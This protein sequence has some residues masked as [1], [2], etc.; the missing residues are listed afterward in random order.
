M[1]WPDGAPL[2]RRR[3]LAQTLGG[4]A[5]LLCASRP[6]LSVLASC[7]P[8]AE[9]K[10]KA[11]IQIWLQG[12][13]PHLDTFDPKPGAGRDY[14]GPYAKSIPTSVDGIEI[15]PQLPLLARE[16]DKYALLRGMTHGNNGHETAAYLVQAG[17][18]AGG[19]LVFPGFGSVVASIKAPK[20]DSKNLLPP[21][22]VVPRPQGRFSEAGFLSSKYKPFATG[23]DPNKDPFAVEGLI[24][25]N[26]TEERQ[27][28]RRDLL[29]RL[30]QF[31]GDDPLARNLDGCREQAYSMILGEAG[32]AF[33]LSQ[34]KKEVRDRYGRTSFGQSCLLARRLVERGVSFVTINYPGWDTHK[35][36]FQTL[37]R[38]LPELDAGLAA[39]LGDLAERGLLETTIVWASG[40]F[41]RTPRI[42][43][44]APWH[45]GRG[46]HGKAFSALVAG[47]GFKGG[48]VVGKTDERG[49]TVVE[50][51]IYPWDLMASMYQLLGIAPDA[52]LT[53]PQGET[54]FVSPLAGK[55]IAA[56]ETAG[57][58]KEIL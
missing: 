32:K 8:K 49:E 9:G 57:I 36:N 41:G 30:D 42:Q 25:E 40:E 3:L 52:R 14:C 17:R 26:V 18:K 15:S 2:S 4:C 38:K 51:P 29:T 43:W 48:R 19:E 53:T 28:D 27:R 7:L 11:V 31:G 58:L 34:E 13:P 35:Q 5:G 45:G 37:G 20:A 1:N 39:L 16:A 46:H 24:A 12:G 55:E 33:T 50:R 6:D 44:E 21:Y 23:G 22:V 54:P 56:K 47:G 10:A